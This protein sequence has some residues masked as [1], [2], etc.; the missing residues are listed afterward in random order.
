MYLKSSIKYECIE[1]VLYYSQMLIDGPI[2]H[3]DTE[4]AKK[5]LKK[6]LKHKDSRIYFLYGKILNSENNSS[7]ARKYF[8]KASKA[9]NAD[10]QFEYGKIE[11]NLRSFISQNFTFF[12]RKLSW[13][14]ILSKNK[15][16]LIINNAIIISCLIYIGISFGLIS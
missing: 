2:V 12:Y 1:S 3:W 5:L 7:E 15:N 14:N 13:I 4:N 6:N 11:I 10:A 9:G 16:T 8:E